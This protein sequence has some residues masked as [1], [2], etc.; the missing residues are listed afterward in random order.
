MADRNSFSADGRRR[1]FAS[2]GFLCLVK[3]AWTVGYAFADHVGLPRNV[4]R[5]V[6]VGRL[7]SATIVPD[8]LARVTTLLTRRQVSDGRVLPAIAAPLRDRTPGL[9]P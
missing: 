4:T 7:R 6:A 8:V 5:Q 2:N 3:L 1:P 9:C